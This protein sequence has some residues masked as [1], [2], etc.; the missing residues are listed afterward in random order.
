MSG[1][2][3]SFIKF[4]HFK[5]LNFILLKL[6]NQTKMNCKCYDIHTCKFKW[7]Y[8]VDKHKNSI[9]INVCNDFLYIWNQYR[10][11]VTFN[12]GAVVTIICSDTVSACTCIKLAPIAWKKYWQHA[13]ILVQ[14]DCKHKISNLDIQLK[15]QLHAELVEQKHQWSKNLVCWFVV[16]QHYSFSDQLSRLKFLQPINYMYCYL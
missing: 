12:W 8:I 10:I 3:P 14:F 11:Y 2:E 6:K 7:P 13:N 9:V 1:F 15:Q 4:R 5:L 16:E